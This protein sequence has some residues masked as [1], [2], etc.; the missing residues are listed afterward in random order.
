MLTLPAAASKIQNEDFSAEAGQWGD[1]AGPPGWTLVLARD[2]QAGIVED[3]DVSAAGGRA[4]RFSALGRGFGES[5]MDQ[6]VALDSPFDALMLSVQ[7]RSDDPSPELALRLR[8][9]FFADQGCSVDSAAAAAEQIETD[10][11]LS[12]ERLAEEGWTRIESA[13]RLASELGPD[14]RSAR[15]SIRLRDRSN[16]GQPR[17]PA[18]VVWFDLASLE[19][20]VVLLPPDQRAALRDLY[21]ATDGPNW[22]EALGWMDAEGTE[23]GWHGV[24]CSDDGST[25]VGLD[26]SANGLLGEVPP[27]IS[28]LTDLEGQTGLDLC[29]NELVFNPA[30]LDFIRDRHLGAEPGL[31]QGLALLP[32][33]RA[34][35]GNYF[36]PLGRD[37]EGFS[38]NMLSSG[39]A[40]FYWATYDDAGKPLWLFGAGRADQRVLRLPA[41]F[42]TR[43][44]PDGFSAEPVGSASIG[45][46]RAEG[47]SECIIGILRF[48]AAGGHFGGS[49]GREL[50][51][52]NQREGCSASPGGDPLI[53]QIAGIWFDP[54]LDGQGLS[55]TPHSDDRVV[56]NWFGYDANGEQV[57][58][59]GIGFAELGEQ[60][61]FEE[62]LAVR[63]GSF[64]DFISPNDLE[65]DRLGSALLTPDGDG[66]RFELSEPDGRQIELELAR[67]KAGPDLLASTGRRID[68][69]MTEEDL[70]E[71]YA[72]G[73]FRDDRLPGELRF[74]GSDEVQALT[75]LRFRGSSS[76]LLPKKSFNIRFENPQALLFGSDRM[77]LNANYTDPTM[78]REAISFELFRELGQPASQTRFFDLWINNVYEGT[79]LHVQRV[80]ETLLV[81]NGLNPNGT[82][83]RDQMRRRA[84]DQPQS[85][86]NFEL[87]GLPEDEREAFLIDHFEFR[88][89]PEWTELLALIEWIQATPP[90]AEF[91]TGFE[92]RFDIDNFIDWLALHWL[93]GDI[94][95]F[96]DDY[97]LYLD[98]EDPAAR[99][100][101]IPWDKDLSFGS[102]FRE[103]FFTDN[104]FFI[105]EYPLLSDW[106]NL[107]IN[108]FLATPELR[109]RAK[110]RLLALSTEV[111]PASWFDARV[112]ALIEQLEDSINIQPGP[113]A[114]SLHDQNHFSTPDLFAKQVETLLEFVRLRARF[115]E[116]QIAAETGALYTATATIESG[117][118]ER[119][120]LTDVSGWTMATVQAIRPSP[121]PLTLAMSMTDNPELNGIIREWTLALDGGP[122]LAE[123]KL[124]YRNEI[125][126]FWG[127]GNWWS[128]GDEPIGRQQELTLMIGA[129]GTDPQPM[130]ATRINPIANMAHVALALNPGQYTLRLEL[131]ET[132]QDQ[133]EE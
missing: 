44:G 13:S 86:F 28:A 8:I 68:L 127:R 108:R 32:F 20:D 64:N 42:I 1:G 34:F 113:L 30:T 5:R 22:Q 66:W 94:D 93:V 121:A 125:T 48:S 90:G 106:D 27:S 103:G 58:R 56:L 85:S 120:F 78:L 101:V 129:A 10:V 97:W 98:H 6:C 4:F 7:L 41:L 124:Y 73:P 91:M 52:L 74:D 46:T 24:H 130:F 25:V 81:Q 19:A 55:F 65:F 126:T 62:L 69:T 12:R 109:Q 111:F 29:W 107:L 71:L 57:W 76:R 2:D 17:E 131:L 115:I 40:S 99:W 95:S 123:L 37:G 51:S 133:T 96:G 31:C 23:C 15:I 49:D 102:H 132:G 110:N 63:G 105:Y 122:L 92:Q 100:M 79:Y 72:R 128:E 83:V 70:V 47:D 67:I 119:V 104:D 16:G 116:R 117:S 84:P 53:E 3:L 9:D 14:V 54:A 26:L 33:S 112:E 50:V 75:G 60:L 89:D 21:L 80:D 43:Q 88:G 45:F 11:G 59:I 39:A 36:Q 87:S 61:L 77:N 118:Q 82:L 114:F 38:L 35:S 18:R